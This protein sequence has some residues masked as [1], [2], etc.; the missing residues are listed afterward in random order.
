MTIFYDALYTESNPLVV[1]KMLGRDGSAPRGRGKWPLPKDGKRGDAMT[2]EGPLSVCENGL[3]GFRG[4]LSLVCAGLYDE[5]LYVAEL[6]GEIV[7]SKN[8]VCAR[9]GRLCYRV[10]TWNEQ[11]Q[12]LWAADCAEVVLPIFERKH[13]TDMRPRLAIRAARRYAFGLID[14]AARA[15]ARAAAGAA[16]RAEAWAAAGD[17]AWAAAGA[18]AGAEA[19]AEAW[20][21]PWAA[22]W[23]AAGAE[24]RAA[25]WDAA[26]DAAR[27]AQAVRLHEY[28]TGAVD[29]NVIR[30]LVSK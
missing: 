13:S 12:R 29:L 1:Y 18:A 7:E 8:K 2:A 9:H 4:L 24:A 5:T 23:V 28:L 26:G 14:A 16:A 19:W 27:A 20:A 25:A 3:H 21:S 11:A 30:E 17:A 22:A 10:E 6:W 15:E